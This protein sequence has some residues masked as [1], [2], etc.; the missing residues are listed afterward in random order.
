MNKNHQLLREDE[1]EAKTGLSRTTRW[2]LAKAGKFPRPVK[3]G[4]RGLNGYLAA[5]VDEWILARVAER[6]AKARLSAQAAA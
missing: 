4:E 2:R 3:L 5:E 6:D 1:V